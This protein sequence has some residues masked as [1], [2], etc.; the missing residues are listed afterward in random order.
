MTSDTDKFTTGKEDGSDKV[1]QQ[2][3][4]FHFHNTT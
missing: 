4:E 2:P 1:D 3:S